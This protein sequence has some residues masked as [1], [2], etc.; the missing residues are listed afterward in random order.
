MLDAGVNYIDT[1]YV[2]HR[3]TA[4][5]LVGKALKDGYREKVSIMTKNPTRMVEKAEDYTKMLDEELERFDFDYIDVY[6]FHGLRHEVYENK[7]LKLGLLDLAK[8][9]KADGKIKHI[10]FWCYTSKGRQLLKQSGLSEKDLIE[11]FCAINECSRDVFYK[12]KSNAFKVHSQRSKDEWE[13]DFGK[14]DLDGSIYLYVISK[15]RER[16]FGNRQRNKNF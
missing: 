5:I 1:A 14:Y 8:K 2:Y 16:W 13:Q 12:H 4:E 7:V 3:Q 11:H 9:A 10:G 6:L 15:K